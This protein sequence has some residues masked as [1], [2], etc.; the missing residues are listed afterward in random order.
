[1]K[2]QERREEWHDALDIAMARWAMDTRGFY[3]RTPLEDLLDWLQPCDAAERMPREGA[4]VRALAEEFT[5]STRRLAK[6]A[7]IT[8][9][10]IWSYEQLQADRKR[11]RGIL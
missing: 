7:T 4:L 3:S 1:M 2:N 11:R 10:M 8:E 5:A 6:E 9:L